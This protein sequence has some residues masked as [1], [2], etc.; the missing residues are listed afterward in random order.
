MKVYRVVPDIFDIKEPSDCRGMESIYNQAGYILYRR[1]KGKVNHQRNSISPT[2]NEESKFF[3]LFP[4]DAIRFGPEV[5]HTNLARLVE[6]DIPQKLVIANA[7]IG[8]YGD[9]GVIGPMAVE[10]AIPYSQLGSGETSVTSFDTKYK[11]KLAADSYSETVDLYKHFFDKD[12]ADTVRKRREAL[13]GA[14]DLMKFDKCYSNCYVVKSDFLTGNMWGFVTSMQGDSIKRLKEK[15]LELDT[16]L[17]GKVARNFIVKDVKE[18]LN[19]EP[20]TSFQTVNS[21]IQEKIP[22]YIKIYQKT[23]TPVIEDKENRPDFW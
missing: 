19:R 7:G 14:V 17:E 13:S 16:S 6:Y 22:E 21:I 8:L 15:G 5:T 3:F 9:E 2:L 18:L 12:M 4:E 20:S 10:T 23:K 1:H 11:R